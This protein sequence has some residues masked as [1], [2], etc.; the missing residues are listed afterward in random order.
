M[1]TVRFVPQAKQS[2]LIDKFVF[3]KEHYLTVKNEIVK[4]NR[5]LDLEAK[6]LE[7]VLIQI[8][9]DQNFASSEFTK[10][11]T[12]RKYHGQFEVSALPV[13]IQKLRF[14]KYFLYEIGIDVK[15]SVSGKFG[16]IEIKCGGENPQDGRALV[17]NIHLQ[18]KQ[19]ST[20][21]FEQFQA[22]LEDFQSLD[23]KFVEEVEK[24]SYSNFVQLGYKVAEKSR[25]VFDMVKRA[26]EQR[27]EQ[28]KQ[29][30]NGKPITPQFQGTAKNKSPT[31]PLQVTNNAQSETD[32]PPFPSIGSKYK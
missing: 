2:H 11:Q 24:V 14:Q 4:Y 12:Q 7:G 9:G 3:F 21:P 29:T 30:K 5:S 32:F 16:N 18:N 26:N 20:P 1:K 19:T 23:P 13:A 17:L 10:D 22:L 25:D 27:A 15:C 6:D 28:E 31:L 8:I